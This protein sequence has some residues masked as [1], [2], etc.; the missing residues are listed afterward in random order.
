MLVSL[1]ICIFGGVL[2]RCYFFVS[3]YMVATFFSVS[4][5]LYPELTA[6]ALPRKERTDRH[7]PPSA[8]ETSRERRSDGAGGA[9]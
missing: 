2:Y 7:Q 9:G 4:S 3:E 6:L 1:Q 8:E 5:C